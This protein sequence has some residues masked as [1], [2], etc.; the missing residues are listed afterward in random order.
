MIDFVC[1]IVEDNQS[2]KRWAQVN[3]RVRLFL[4]MYQ[5]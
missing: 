1:E 4:E 3:V 5:I 2:D